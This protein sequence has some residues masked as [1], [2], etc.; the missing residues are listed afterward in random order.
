MAEE[1][2][3][4]SW[5]GTLLGI[6]TATAG[7][8]TATAGLIGALYQAG[9]FHDA[10]KASHAGSAEAATAP[11]SKPAVAAPGT[12]NQSSISGVSAESAN[13]NSQ[14]KAPAAAK[15]INLFSTDNS[16]TL[17][18]ASSD[19]WKAT[20]D[21]KEDM[22]YIGNALGKEA[23][24]SFKDDR[25]AAFDTFTMLI[26]QTDDCNV[27][28]FE[29]LAGND[30]AAGTFESLGKFHTQNA[31]SF[32]T[33]YQAFKFTEVTAKYVKFKPLTSHGPSRLCIRE[34]QLFGSLK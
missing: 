10:K 31:K 33:P 29:L 9:F 34:F 32:K 15:Q 11:V 8:I 5:W 28:E 24:Y 27:K 14:I 6:L 2:K 13:R 30:L 22:A 12:Q 18:V 1:V 3:P 19:D 21:S 16:A 4:Q 26:S 23:I 25:T 7:I 17:V 20:I